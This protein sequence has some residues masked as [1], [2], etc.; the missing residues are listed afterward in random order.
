M[1][2][3]SAVNPTG[4]GVLMIISREFF[5]LYVIQHLKNRRETQFLQFVLR[6][7]KFADGREIL[8]RNIVKFAGCS[9]DVT[10]MS[11]FPLAAPAAVIF[12]MVVATPF[13][14]SSVSVNQ[15]RLRFCK[16]I[17]ISPVN[18]LKIARNHFREGA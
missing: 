11:S 7:F 1:A 16:A 10:T 18:S 12:R 4:P 8:D 5:P 17:G 15:A 3:S 14:S 9:R 6:Q 13:T 2:A